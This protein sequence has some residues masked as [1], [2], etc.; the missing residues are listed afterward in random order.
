MKHL[1]PA[2]CSLR[3][4]AASVWMTISLAACGGLPPNDGPSE[5]QKAPQTAQGAENPAPSQQEVLVPW[6]FIT[7]GRLTT[8]VD[9][10]GFPGPGSLQGF[11]TLVN[12]SA[13]AARGSDIYI[14]DSGARKLY[15]FDSM[16]QTLTV[17]PGVF[18]QSWTRLQVGV[19]SSLFVLDAGNSTILHY[20]RGGRL[21][22]TL[23]DPLTSA[24]LTEFAVDESLSKIVANDQLNG[25]MV[26]L[27]LLG[28][29]SRVMDSANI[30][31]STSMG[32]IATAGRTIY[33]LDMRCSCIVAMDDEGRVSERIGKG[34]LT[35]PRTLA[36]DRYGYIFVADEVEHTLKVF[37]RGAL[38][39]SYGAQT[40]GVMEISALAADEGVLY[41]ADSPGARV[42]ALR[43]R[44][45][46]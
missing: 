9:A 8:Q 12:P 16:L 41:V 18:A 37:L 19:D 44:P 6:Q 4:F 5:S 28:K 2:P 22:Q 31:E 26:V 39:A 13:L 34:V 14:A 42:V 43:I 25:R 30:G 23:S 7:G 35:Q 11:T 17:I 3:A 36:V 1:A 15:R 46:K 27:H 32:A 20:T 24:R 33:A 40:L 21:L 45:P 29:A 38:V 10:N